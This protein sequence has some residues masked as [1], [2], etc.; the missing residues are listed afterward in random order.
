MRNSKIKLADALI[1][2][3]ALLNDLVL[4]TRNEE[5]FAI[6]ELTLAAF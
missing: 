6:L 4:I 1:A 2:A 3:T 5:D